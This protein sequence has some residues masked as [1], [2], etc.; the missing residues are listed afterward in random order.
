VSGAGI[1]GTQVKS[2]GNKYRVSP[3]RRLDGA[4][5]SETLIGTNEIKRARGAHLLSAS[6]SSLLWVGWMFELSPCFLD[7]AFS[8]MGSHECKCLSLSLVL[9]SSCF[10]VI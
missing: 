1:R 10:V 7:S 5:F 3:S 2:S 8:A 6:T 4:Y 9:Q